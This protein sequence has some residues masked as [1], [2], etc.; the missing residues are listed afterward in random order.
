MKL[1]FPFALIFIGLGYWLNFV[2]KAW[3]VAGNVDNALLVNSYTQTAIFGLW[4]M[5]IGGL[6]LLFRKQ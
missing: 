5:V 4:L 1:I 3:S 2:I 6:W